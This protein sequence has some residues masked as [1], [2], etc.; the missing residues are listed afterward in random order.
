MPEETWKWIVY[1]HQRIQWLER[2]VQ[3]T[4]T[5]TARSSAVARRCKGELDIAPHE[6]KEL[7]GLVATLQRRLDRL[8]GWRRGKSDPEATG[9]RACANSPGAWPPRAAEG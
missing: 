1:I 4:N 2:G 7:S 8:E 3:V 6:T 9:T 5:Q